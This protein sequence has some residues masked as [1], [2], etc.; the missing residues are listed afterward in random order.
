MNKKLITFFNIIFS[1]RGLLFVFLFISSIYSFKNFDH[2]HFFSFFSGLF[3]KS[4]F[5]SYYEGISSASHISISNDKKDWSNDSNIIFLRGDLSHNRSDLFDEIEHKLWF[6]IGYN[7][8]IKVFSK[9]DNKI[10]L[11]FLINSTGGDFYFLVKL[12]EMLSLA[13]ETDTKIECMVTK[14]SASVALYVTSRCDY[15]SFYK[16]SWLMWHEASTPLS[17]NEFSN[18]TMQH[19]EMEK[20][21]RKFERDEDLKLIFLYNINEKEFFTHKKEASL[22]PI[23]VFASRYHN[24]IIIV[25]EL[26]FPD[27]I[28]RAFYPLNWNKKNIYMDELNFFQKRLLAFLFGDYRKVFSSNNL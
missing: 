8:F 19:I 10:N 21:I 24:N 3:S 25:N 27:S 11:R 17:R 20:Y 26:I 28:D 13:S 2:K 14:L 16:K 4:N 9:S 22:W 6:T 7:S 1:L 18:I 12:D 5:S 23:E 15:I